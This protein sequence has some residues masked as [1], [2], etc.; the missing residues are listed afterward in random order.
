MVVFD[1]GW[2]LVAGTLVVTGVAAFAAA[3]FAATAVDWTVARVRTGIG[4]L[5][6]TAG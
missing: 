2:A 3:W 5:T 6:P 1:L 4:L